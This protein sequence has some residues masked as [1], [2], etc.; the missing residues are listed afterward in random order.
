MYES[1]YVKKLAADLMTRLP[2]LEWK[3]AALNPALLSQSIPKS[4]FRGRE[5]SPAS[6]IAELKSDLHVLAQQ[7]G[8]RSAFYLAGQIQRKVDV[9]VGAYKIHQQTAQNSTAQSFSM[10]RLNTRAQW[11]CSLEE[12]IS[13]LTQ[14][15]QAL[16]STLE[17][18]KGKEDTPDLLLTIQAELGAVERKL[19]LAQEALKKAIAVD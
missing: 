10:T 16:K 3:I 13:V 17:R 6:C 4:L 5:L 8:S 2:E 15:Q 7:N 1:S 19:T 14:Q 18:K 9:L 11:L 12:D